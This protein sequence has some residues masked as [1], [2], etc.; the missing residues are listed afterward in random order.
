M[1]INR[2]ILAKGLSLRAAAI[3]LDRRGIR[4]AQGGA[5]TATQV[6]RVLAQVA[7]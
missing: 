6:S 2:T 7:A 3:E 4:T 1:P 5:W